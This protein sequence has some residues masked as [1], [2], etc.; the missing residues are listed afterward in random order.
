MGMPPTKLYSLPP[1][2]KAATGLI[3]IHDALQG[4]TIPIEVSPFT[5]RSLNCPAAIIAIW[6]QGA[7]LFPRPIWSIHHRTLFR[8]ADSAVELMIRILDP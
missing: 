6:A 2:C 7:V 1:V 3:A 4:E 8:T 5:V